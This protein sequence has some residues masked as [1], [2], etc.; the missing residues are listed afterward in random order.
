MGDGPTRSIVVA[1]L[2]LTLAACMSKVNIPSIPDFGAIQGG[3]EQISAAAQVCSQASGLISE[4]TQALLRGVKSKDPAAVN[5]AAAELTTIA[6]RLHQSAADGMAAS[7]SMSSIPLGG[8]QA[9]AAV[10]AT[11]KMC[12]AIGGFADDLATR[13]STTGSHAYKELEV[14][15][16]SM[17]KKIQDAA[18]E[19]ES[20]MQG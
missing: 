10:K 16:E 12:D 2:A 14:A 4:Q 1:A 20:S 18:T 9:E 3:A 11:F 7:S 8:G 17:S 15:T 13:V 19:M 6:D 5:A